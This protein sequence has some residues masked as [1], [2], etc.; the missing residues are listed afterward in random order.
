LRASAG[1]C[2]RARAASLESLLRN[3]PLRVLAIGLALFHFGNA[4]M[5]PMVGQRL[6]L[7][8]AGYESA[9]MSA[10]IVGAQMVMLP[11]ALWCGAWADRVGRKP[12]LIVACA[13]LALRGVLYTLSSEP[14]W[15]LGV[16]LLDGVGAGAL[17][18]V[19][20]LLVADLTRGTGRYNVSL[21]AAATLSGIGAALS[22]AV[23]GMIV[24]RYGYD[25]AFATL[26]AIALGA[27]A[28]FWR[29]LPETSERPLPLLLAEARRG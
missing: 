21:G 29:L 14:G 18:V 20:P 7:A 3:V 9:M 11:V 19:V 27:L 17:G 12:I 23:A 4:A 13:V 6:A 8:H 15:L 2:K 26:G 10:C 5:L 25:A 16:Q 1:E 24:V 22:N 28:L